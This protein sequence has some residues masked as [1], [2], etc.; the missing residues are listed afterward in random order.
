MKAFETVLTERGQ[1]SVPAFIRKKLGLSPGRKLLWEISGEGECRVII[2]D[3]V[4][5]AD[6]VSMVG[7]LKKIHPHEKRTTEQVMAE[8]REGEK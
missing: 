7:F 5:A 4:P 6:P 1:T 2:E 3:S 8:L